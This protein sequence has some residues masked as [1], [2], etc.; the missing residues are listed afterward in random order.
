MS[1]AVL[2]LADILDLVGI[3]DDAPGDQAGRLRFRDYLQ[4]RV[5]EVGQ[6]RDYIEECLRNTGDRY[7]RALQDLVNRLGE[8][9]G[10][11]VT[12]GRYQGVQ[13]QIGFDGH[14]QSATDYHLVVEVKTSTA[15]TIPTDVLLGYIN[16]LIS[17]RTIASEDQAL[18]LYVVGRP[19]AKV[20]ELERAIVGER[21]T[22]RLRVI[23]LDALLTLAETMDE[24]GTTHEDILE[25]LRPSG[26]RIDGIV[27]LLTRLVA[28]RPPVEVVVAPVDSPSETADG[29]QA[30]DS[31][32]P[33]TA[34]VA[35]YYLTPVASDDAQSAEE[36][37]Q[38]LVGEAHIYAF[39]NRTPGRKQLKPGD[40]IC[41]NAT[42]KG[43]IGHA[44][45]AS[46]PEEKRDRRVRHPE[47][48][49][50]V[51][52][53]DHVSL[54]LDRPRVIDAALRSRLDAFQKRD[55]NAPWA[56]F[57]QGTKRITEHDF[58]I[59]AREQS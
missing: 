18:G 12:Y 4:R 29:R 58:E 26:P 49:P 8:F 35:T 55:P 36:V 27:S 48:Y 5:E 15:Y 31:A 23:S 3:L 7:N 43:V 42:G 44:R 9:L 2:T 20:Q 14:W 56:W 39:G 46:V 37:V 50:W 17:Q 16:G 6:L 59:L 41:F 33:D 10:F 47:K 25:V 51:F 24:Y 11:K 34:T 30:V 53:L 52:R 22:Q 21:R 13:G 40:W 32:R 19:D 57:V 45:V 38:T 28:G 54:H 1:A